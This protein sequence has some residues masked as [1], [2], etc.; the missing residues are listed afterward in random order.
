MSSSTD[1]TTAA[2]RSG[3]HTPDNVGDKMAGMRVAATSGACDRIQRAGHHA[4]ACRR[5]SCRDGGI[6][7]SSMAVAAAT[8]NDDPGQYDTQETGQGGNPFGAG[9]ALG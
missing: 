1:P 5:T 7:R 2:P 4:G 6:F 3:S 9:N 8:D